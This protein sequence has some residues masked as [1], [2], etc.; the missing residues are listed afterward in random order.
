[1]PKPQVIYEIVRD[2]VRATIH[3]EEDGCSIVL[4][5]AAQTR[6][7]RADNHE[8]SG[9]MPK[10]QEALADAEAYLRANPISNK[11]KSRA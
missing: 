7:G 1:M 5:P 10:V 8:L 9:E 6:P 4:A 11:Q 2:G 3:R